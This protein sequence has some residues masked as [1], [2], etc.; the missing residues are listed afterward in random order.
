MAFKKCGAF[1]FLTQTFLGLIKKIKTL[2]VLWMSSLGLG[3]PPATF[4]AILV[5]VSRAAIGGRL[6][7]QEAQVSSRFA[8]V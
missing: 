1:F 2:I 4:A 5:A 6:G 7:S 3:S 8:K